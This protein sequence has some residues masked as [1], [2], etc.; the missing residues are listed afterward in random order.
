M[1]RISSDLL[2]LVLDFDSFKWW[3]EGYDKFW[4]M[5]IYSSIEFV[6][7]VKIELFGFDDNI[8]SMDK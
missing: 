7:I 1:F 6:W 8:I 4:H 2:S 3:L 5:D